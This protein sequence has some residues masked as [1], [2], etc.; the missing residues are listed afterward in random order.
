MKRKLILVVLLFLFWIKPNQ[1]TAQAVVVTYQV[2]YDELSPYGQWINYPNYGY[3]WVPAV[4][5]G[6]SP[7]SSNGHWVFTDYGWTWV[8]NYNW[9]WAPFHYGRWNYDNYY[10]WL[11]FPN[12]EWGPAWVTWRH[13][14]GYYGWAPMSSGISVDASFGSGYNVP[15]ERWRFVR[16]RDL[17]RADINRYYIN[18]S[19]N[20]TIIKNSTVITNTGR[21]NSRNVV[22]VAGPK[23]EDFQRL[24][25]RKISPIVIHDDSHPG[26]KQ[27]GNDFKIYRPQIK[28]EGANDKKLTPSKV[29]EYKPQKNNQGKDI[30]TRDVKSGDQRQPVKTNSPGDKMN[31]PKSP[32]KINST[33]M[34]KNINQNQPAKKK[35]SPQ[36][37]IPDKNHQQQAPDRKQHEPQRQKQVPDR[38]QPPPEKTPQ[39]QNREG[40]PTVNPPQQQRPPQQQPQQQFPDKNQPYPEQKPQH[41]NREG[42][43]NVRP[44][45]NRNNQERD[46]NRK[47]NKENPPH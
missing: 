7:Y 16:D 11:W 34:D 45:P 22:Y 30:K 44:Q 47:E 31:N 17:N 10:G 23:R 12:T 14:N 9:G 15:N 35:Q 46:P 4:E 29:S 26:Q 24:T 8:S 33:P 6:F 13:S 19:Q 28:S 39:H 25:T 27:S 43:P 18:R 21:D 20:I 42:S 37:Q 3:V 1:S 38:N 41:Q 5:T 36:Q 2:F 32:G 40:S